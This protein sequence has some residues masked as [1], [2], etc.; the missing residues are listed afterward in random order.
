MTTI[1]KEDKILNLA[2]T[3]EKAVNTLKQ[4]DFGSYATSR[5]DSVHAKTGAMLNR[6]DDLKVLFFS[7]YL[8]DLG[9]NEIEAHELSSYLDAITEHSAFECHHSLRLAEMTAST[10]FAVTLLL[11]SL[12]RLDNPSAAMAKA[13]VYLSIAL[14][15]CESPGYSYH[16]KAPKYVRKDILHLLVN[17]WRTED[18]SLLEMVGPY[19]HIKSIL[20]P[21]STQ[22][23]KLVITAKAGFE[24]NANYYADAQLWKYYVYCYWNSASIYELIGQ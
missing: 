7:Y 1:M 15:D 14:S 20:G 5:L 6:R 21:A 2:I 16:G 19:D 24:A 18:T 11:E 13:K 10:L 12:D 9:L 8:K 22:A 23:L 4:L 3:A 17:D